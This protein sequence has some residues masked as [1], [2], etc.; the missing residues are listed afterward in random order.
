MIRSL[1]KET[2]RQ[3]RLGNFHQTDRR[4]RPRAVGTS[5]VRNRRAP[6]E[7]LVARRPTPFDRPFLFE[8][9]PWIARDELRRR[10]VLR[11]VSRTLPNERADGD[12]S[13]CVLT[14]PEDPS[15]DEV[16][17]RREGDHLVELRAFPTPEAPRS[18]PSFV[19]RT[20]SPSRP[21]ASSSPTSNA[22]RTD[23]N[24]LDSPRDS[25]WD[26]LY[27]RQSM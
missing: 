22:E 10:E 18:T 3:V 27:R 9:L 12:A 7:V 6:R 8:T 17:S 4:R 19:S 25:R 16:P 5:R 20:S 21:K 14:L 1:R 13:I 24:N 23:T 26:S 15:P 2:N 11:D